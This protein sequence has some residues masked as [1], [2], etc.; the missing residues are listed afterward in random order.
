MAWRSER[1]KG[2][3]TPLS[4]RVHELSALAYGNLVGFPLAG[5]A[6][7]VG[8]MAAQQHHDNVHFRGD[9]GGGATMC[10]EQAGAAVLDIAVEKRPGLV[11]LHL[12][13]YRSL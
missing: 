10:V 3:S 2:T 5:S 4:I 13:D 12:R 8:S 6:E 7:P 1:C 9:N 11:N